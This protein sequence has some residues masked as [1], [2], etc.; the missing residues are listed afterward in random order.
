MTLTVVREPTSSLCSP[1]AGAEFTRTTASFSSMRDPRPLPM[2]LP[3][4]PTTVRVPVAE[5]EALGSSGEAAGPGTPSPASSA[6]SERAGAPM[7][8]GSRGT[9]SCPVTFS[10]DT[11]CEAGATLLGPFTRAGVLSSRCGCARRR[12]DH[13]PQGR[14]SGLQPPPFKEEKERAPQPRRVGISSQFCWTRETTLQAERCWFWT[15]RFARCCRALKR[16]KEQIGRE[17]TAT[18]HKT[19]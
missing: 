13:L 5:V 10:A 14:G 1:P 8:R 2:E 15:F 6:R 12:R 4:F 17:R 7:P 16:E 19:G 11:S 3:E 18:T 9:T